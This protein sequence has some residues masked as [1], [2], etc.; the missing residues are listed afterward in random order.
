[1]QLPS[2]DVH[3]GD[4]LDVLR[5]KYADEQFD[6]I[7]TSPPYADRRMNTY[8]GIKLTRECAFKMNQE[9]VMVPMGEWKEKGGR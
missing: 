9:A 1:M 5:K 6:L 3:S 4:C 2:S 7:V 8:G